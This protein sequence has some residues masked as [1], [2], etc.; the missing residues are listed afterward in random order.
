[1]DNNTISNSMFGGVETQGIWNL[2]L[3]SNLITA[4]GTT[5]IT[6]DS[7]YSGSGNLGYN[8]VTNLNPGQSA[9]DNYSA[10]TFT[11]TVTGN[12]WQGGTTSFSKTINFDV[13]GGGGGVNYVGQGAYS[14]PGNNYWNAIV[15]EAAPRLP[16]PIL[17]VSP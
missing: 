9:Y 15:P 14:D 10:G 2:L 3:Q 11:A 6:I 13:P 17:M 5:G 4:P 8:T 12:S 1:M 7:G 16:A